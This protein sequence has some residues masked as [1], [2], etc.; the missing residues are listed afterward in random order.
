MINLQITALYAGLLGLLYL[1]LFYNVVKL[2]YKHHVLLLDGG[3]PDLTVA[4][5]THANFTENVPFAL[6]LLAL[7]E[8]GGYSHHI[9]YG[10]G[11]FLFL[12]RILHSYGMDPEIPT[13]SRKAGA[14]MTIIYLFVTSIA[15]LFLGVGITL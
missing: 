2:R 13:K 3:H 11:G 15:V 9:L 4:I 5:R 14:L 10:L 6:L 1:V 8:L 7:L 12:S